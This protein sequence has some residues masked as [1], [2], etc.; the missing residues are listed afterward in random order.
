MRYDAIVIGCGGVGS[1][2]LFHLASR[3]ARVLGLD[4]F[5]PGHDHGSSH[6]ATRVIRQ[7][8]FE[9][10]DYVPLLQR[11]YAL[12]QALEQRRSQRLYVETGV[13]AIGPPDGAVLSGTL[14][15][16][17]RHALPVERLNAQ[18]LGERFPGFRVPDGYAGVLE[19]NGGYL[20]VEDCVIAHAGLAE[21]LGAE[22]R[23]GE[24]VTGWEADDSGVVVHTATGAYRGERLVVTAG[25]WAGALLADLGVALQPLRKH[26]HWYGTDDTRYRQG[27]GCPVFFY[28]LPHGT[29]YGFPQRDS[30]GVKVAEHSGGEPIR[31]PSRLDRSLDQREQRRNEQF[32]R[33]HLP[34]VT[35]PRTHHAVCMYTMSPDEHFL[36]D[37][38]PRHDN[39][40]F[41]AGL[42]GHGFKFASV[43]G[44]ILAELALDG[45]TP[46]PC[47]FLSL[48][49]F[50]GSGPARRH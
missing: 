32:V 12:W 39:V 27:N 49:R 43:L 34:G 23:V 45:A 9:H 40:L 30:L 28:D 36:L 8:Y 6:G 13:L 1:A 24:A 11:A 22:L 41:C 5:P 38:H 17:A 44:A 4:R 16:A 35:G 15:S 7:A 2:A 21:T 31:D 50:A 10:P 3:D 18:Q 14:H 46:S 29:F 37:R 42:S 33:S 19:R 48:A 47:G 20:H 26:L 25:A